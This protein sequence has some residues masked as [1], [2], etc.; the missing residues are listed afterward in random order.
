MGVL[1]DDYIHRLATI[2]IS[3]SYSVEDLKLISRTGVK[4]I[5][6]DG[7]SA[8]ISKATRNRTVSDKT[9]HAL[10]ATIE[11][12]NKGDNATT[13]VYLILK[14]NNVDHKGLCRVRQYTDTRDTCT[15]SDISHG[16]KTLGIS[17][18]CKLI[19]MLNKLT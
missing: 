9:A 11:F 1:K 15:Y 2:G 7:V 10:E 3:D 5:G 14:Y 18:M 4:V 12:F 17:P 13:L 6:K 16:L 19:M 8:F